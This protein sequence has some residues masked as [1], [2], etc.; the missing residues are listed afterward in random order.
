[1]GESAVVQFKLNLPV[2][3]REQ[4]GEAASQLSRS[5]SAE[6]IA[7]LEASFERDQIQAEAL[8][9]LDQVMEAV[10]SLEG[11]VRDLEVFAGY[12]IRSDDD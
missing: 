8:A 2:K 1:M 12:R 11:R 9:D 4:L 7:R 3:L 10:A 5:V 6:M